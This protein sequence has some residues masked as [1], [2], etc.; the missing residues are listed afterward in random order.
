MRRP[1]YSPE[2]VKTDIRNHIVTGV[3]EAIGG[4][5]SASE[6]E[7][8]LT[9]HL[10]STLKVPTRVVN[11]LEGQINGPWR[12]SL[13]YTKFRG[14][15]PSATE[16][17]LGADGIFEIT[18]YG[19]GSSISKSLLFQSKMKGEGGRKLVKQCAKL[20][21]WREAAFVLS[22]GEDA[23]TAISLDEVLSKRG[24]T[25]IHGIPLADYLAGPFVN[26]DVGDTD[27]HYRPRE[28]RLVWRAMTGHT[29]AV[30]FVVK[31]RFR[32]KVVAPDADSA[33]AGIDKEINPAQIHNFRMEASDED[34]LARTFWD[35]ANLGPS[36]TNAVKNLSSRWVAHIRSRGA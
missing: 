19:G 25:K 30:K 26:C 17:F 6:D 29:V 15:G 23:F 24:S 1:L 35:C 34:I 33:V 20:S 14:K 21:T 36:K 9:G 11:V 31:H 7:D 22:F 13:T 18:F 8:T 28:Q 12:W 10:G 27:L 2:E 16:T 3:M 4:F 32:L 5:E